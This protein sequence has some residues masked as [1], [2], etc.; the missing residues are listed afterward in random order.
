MDASGNDFKANRRAPK[1]PPRTT[2]TGMSGRRL[3]APSRFRGAEKTFQQSKRNTRRLRAKLGSVFQDLC[4][5]TGA[6]GA[7]EGFVMPGGML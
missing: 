4:T 7:F 5:L 2:S 6:A 1:G 3:K